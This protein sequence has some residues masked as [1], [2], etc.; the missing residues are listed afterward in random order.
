MSINEKVFLI[1]S[2]ELKIILIFTCFFSGTRSPSIRLRQESLSQSKTTNSQSSNSCSTPRTHS[3]PY[4][5]QNVINNFLSFISAV[6]FASKL[7]NYARSL[8]VYDC[9]HIGLFPNFPCLTK[10]HTIKWYFVKCVCARAP[11]RLWMCVCV[12]T[13]GNAAAH[14]CTLYM[15]IF[16][17]SVMLNCNLN[18]FMTNHIFSHLLHL[19]Y[20]NDKYIFPF[21]HGSCSEACYM[22]HDLYC[23]ESTNFYVHRNRTMHLFLF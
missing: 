12:L 19:T 17:C 21:P 11:A 5:H 22:S 8:F 23:A 7:H 13:Y 6:K 15:C 16:V 18:I 2:C 3:M 4:K 20:G 1:S 14:T 9:T 10:Q